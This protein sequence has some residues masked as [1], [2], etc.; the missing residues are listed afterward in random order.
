MSAEGEDHTDWVYNS[1]APSRPL[2]LDVYQSSADET[3]DAVASAIAE[4][5]RLIDTAPSDPVAL[6]LNRRLLHLIRL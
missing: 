1:A 5:Y 6:Y 3:A 2:G 4:G